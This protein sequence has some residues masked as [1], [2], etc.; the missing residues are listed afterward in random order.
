M[1]TIK[2]KNSIKSISNIDDTYIHLIQVIPKIS[3]KN[4]YY[5]ILIFEEGIEYKTDPL[6]DYQPNKELNI[7]IN[8]YLKKLKDTISIIGEEGKDYIIDD[9]TIQDLLNYIIEDTTLFYHDKF[10]NIYYS[11]EPLSFHKI[12][13]YYN[14]ILFTKYFKLREYI[15]DVYITINKQKRSYNKKY[16]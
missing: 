13:N 3:N 8:D 5:F 4:D 12:N 10:T 6:I 7:D 15:D 2:I 16:N 1:N 9:I 11:Y 14:S